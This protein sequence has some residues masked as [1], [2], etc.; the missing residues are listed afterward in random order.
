MARPTRLTRPS[1]VVVGSVNVDFVVRVTQLPRPGTTVTGGSFERHGGGK[2]ANAAV[3]AARAGAAVRFVGA[4]GDDDLGAW[5]SAELASEG[6]DVSALTRIAGSHTGVALI[7]VDPVGENQIAVASGAN[8]ALDGTIVQRALRAVK[9]AAG[10]I[11]LLGFEIGDDALIGA[12]A[13]AERHGVRIVANPAPARRI[14]EALLALRPILT[15]NAAEAMAL[16]RD[17]SEEAAAWALHEASGAPVLV[18]S[19]THGVLVVDGS[20]ARR[21]RAFP[22]VA[23]DTT[24]AGDVFNGALAAALSQ[25]EGLDS[26]IRWAMA[27]AALSTTVRGARSAPT[28]SAVREFLRS[29]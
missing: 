11:C 3:A 22:V 7:A 24:G 15:P 6:I 26:A 12:A 9:P 19:G 4:V 16:T 18:T 5:Q 1:V 20:A 29:A 8:A 2:G 27:A 21:L 17:A 13:W 23:V 25:G 10:A 14:P 28:G